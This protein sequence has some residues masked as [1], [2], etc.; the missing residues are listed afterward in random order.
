[1]NTSELCQ[2]YFTY[3][4]YNGVKQFWL[5]YIT[6]NDDVKLIKF[7]V[8]RVSV[9]KYRINAMVN[10]LHLLWFLHRTGY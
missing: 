9:H 8:M 2:I 6:D 4:F 5:H 10:V 1:M 7:C 3:N